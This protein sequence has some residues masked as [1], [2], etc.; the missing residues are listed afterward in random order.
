MSADNIALIWQWGGIPF[1]LIGIVYAVIGLFERGV[2]FVG[3]RTFSD[4]VVSRLAVG[5]G[6]AMAWPF[7]L[8]FLIGKGALALVRSVLPSQPND[9]DPVPTPAA[10]DVR[11]FE[12]ETLEEL[13]PVAGL[14]ADLR[15]WDQ[16]LYD[17]M[18]EDWFFNAAE[19]DAATLDSVA[20]ELA[21]EFERWANE[22]DVD[23]DQFSN[24]SAF[25]EHLQHEA[26]EF[27]QGWRK[28]I[29]R[30]ASQPRSAA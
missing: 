29:A 16:R 9:S 5:V 1:F 30:H 24:P 21:D 22:R 6:L 19:D 26:I 8:A 4:S 23:Y 25:R 7:A 11:S 12:V 20:E 3:Y 2:P 14:I 28:N 13:M 17:F 10:A 27:V 18:G 15:D